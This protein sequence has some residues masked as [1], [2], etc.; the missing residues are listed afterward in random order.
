MEKP[1]ITPYRTSTGIQIGQFY[2]RRQVTDHSHDME[3]LQKALLAN[4]DEIRREKL[5][6]IIYI[7][8]V[9]LVFFFVMVVK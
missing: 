2:E 3:L 9:V 5:R 1:K 6:N 8:S 4:P 7:A